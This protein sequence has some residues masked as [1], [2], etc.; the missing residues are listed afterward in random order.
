M[1]IRLWIIFNLKD[2]KISKFKKEV[3]GILLAVIT[4]VQIILIPFKKI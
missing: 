4:I 1:A 2:L 3:G